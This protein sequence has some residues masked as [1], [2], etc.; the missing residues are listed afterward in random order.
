MSLLPKEYLDAVVSIERKVADGSF[1][2]IATGFLVGLRSG[3]ISDKGEEFFNVFLVTNKHVIEEEENVW[4]RFNKGETSQRYVI[5]LIDEKGNKI[6]LPHPNPSVDLVVIYILANKLQE[7]GVEFKFFPEDILAFSD[8]MKELGV[9]QGDEIFVLGF[10][11]GISGKEKKYVIVRGG[12]I[13]RFDNEIIQD[14]SSFL[15][16]SSVFP[17]NSGSPVILK[18]SNISFEGT[19]PIDKAFVIG[20]VSSY[21]PYMETAYSLQMSTPQP[22]I[23]FTE[24]SGLARVVPL[25]YI[26][27]IVS[28]LISKSKE[29]ENQVIADTTSDIPVVKK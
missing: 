27:D 22:R 19:K 4:V 6:W 20:V 24:N 8:K 25:D 17:G 12:I 14:S 10:P 13:A 5:N 16:D 21:I 26:S 28:D 3:R 23:T 29:E 11:M 1:N 15:I 2:T 18:P 7:D 9:S